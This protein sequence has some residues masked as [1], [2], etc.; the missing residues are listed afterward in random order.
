MGVVTNF[1]D[2]FDTT[3]I[4]DE[5]L[6][7]INKDIHLS[8]ENHLAKSYGYYFAVNFF[9]HPTIDKIQQGIKPSSKAQVHIDFLNKIQKVIF[10]Y[11]TPIQIDYTDW[12][13]IVKS[14]LDPIR[15]F[16]I[17]DNESLTYINEH[18]EKYRIIETV[19]HILYAFSSM[20]A[21]ENKDFYISMW[22]YGIK[23][24]VITK[25]M[26]GETISTNLLAEKLDEQIINTA[27]NASM[28]RWGNKVE[29]QRKRYLEHFK[30][31]GFTTYKACAMWIYEN[32]NPENLDFDTIK[33][34]LS[35]AD[36][37][38]FSNK[39]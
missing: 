24:S 31:Q 22:L 29:R 27:K 23:M 4:D 17:E 18:K 11:I 13:S 9:G 32:D 37:G 8:L 21:Y 25:Q 30:Q 36:K 33:K 26:S 10:D 35:Q 5:K 2:N 19:K 15:N 6:L 7:K 28:K 14:Y 38:N 16:Q 1:I 3:D 39:K 20:K 12:Q 34:H